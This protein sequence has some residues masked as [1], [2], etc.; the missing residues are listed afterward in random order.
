MLTHRSLMRDSVNAKGQLFLW[1]LLQLFPLRERLGNHLTLL[2][3]FGLV[4]TSSNDSWIEVMHLMLC[5]IYN[6][7]LK[8]TITS[9]ILL[10]LIP[11]PCAFP[12][13]DGRF[14]PNPRAHDDACAE[15]GEEVDLFYKQT[16]PVL[17]G[18]LWDRLFGLVSYSDISFTPG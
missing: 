2:D 7:S 15:H 16:G 12:D 4:I 10:L 1:I 8:I 3:A 17:D 13:K 9:E 11:A 14:G 18:T 6:H 5:S